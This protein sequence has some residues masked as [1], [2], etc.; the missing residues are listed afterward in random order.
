MEDG[1]L[2]GLIDWF[3]GDKVT[4][5]PFN[6][7]G[8]NFQY[9]DGALRMECL[10]GVVVAPRDAAGHK[11][12]CQG[13]ATHQVKKSR[14]TD[15][16]GETFGKWKVVEFDRIGKNRT[17]YWIVVCECGQGGSVSSGHLMH[18]ASQSCGCAAAVIKR[19]KKVA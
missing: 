12:E 2:Q 15:L 16:T 10:C 3:R 8:W 5:K 9:T 4:L 1:W 14:M 11:R 17:P 7:D 13:T 19:E 6:S 18:G